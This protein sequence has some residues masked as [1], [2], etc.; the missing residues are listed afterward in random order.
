MTSVLTC[1]FKLALKL[2]CLSLSWKILTEE[3]QSLR[4]LRHFRLTPET[5]NFKAKWGAFCR[6]T[7]A[8]KRRCLCL[9]PHW[10]CGNWEST[11]PMQ[12][13]RLKWAQLTHFSNVVLVMMFGALLFKQWCSLSQCLLC[14]YS[15]MFVFFND[16]G[17]MEQTNQTSPARARSAQL[18]RTFNIEHRHVG[19][20]SCWHF[21]KDLQMTHTARRFSAVIIGLIGRENEV[22]KAIKKVKYHFE[23]FPCAHCVCEDIYIS[24]ESTFSIIWLM[25]HSFYSFHFELCKWCSV[26]GI[27]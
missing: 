18:G 16:K 24:E 22:D 8:L 11:Q 9:L 25:R 17:N 3:R 27:G 21:L 1:S 4:L 13:D 2:V 5:F 10:L 7:R 15:F 14:I 6:E 12:A 20:L 26:Q 19:F 23:Y